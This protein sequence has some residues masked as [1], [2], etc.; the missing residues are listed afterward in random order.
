[1]SK[2]RNRVMRIRISLHDS[3]A[4]TPVRYARVKWRLVL[5]F[6]CAQ[7][8]GRRGCVPCASGLG[9]AV[10]VRRRLK[11]QIM[12]KCC[13]ANTVP[14]TGPLPPLKKVSSHPFSVA[15]TAGS[16]SGS[17]FGSGSAARWPSCCTTSAAD[18]AAPLQRSTS[19]SSTTPPRA[20]RCSCRRTQPAG[21]GAAPPPHTHFRP[22]DTSPPT[23]KRPPL[24]ARVPRHRR[25]QRARSSGRA[26]DLLAQRRARGAAGSP[27]A[28]GRA[29]APARRQ[30]HARVST[31]R[32]RL[33][34]DSS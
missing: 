34:L 3:R 2:S 25:S 28:A 17:V 30:P 26:Q 20:S 13:Y 7:R 19:S 27:L 4:S 23:P 31:R 10:R 14:N 8:E 9:R 11:T 15:A 22:S 6:S 18:A 24:T 12:Y 32:R 1:M 21:P 5:T 16:G 29:G 33:T